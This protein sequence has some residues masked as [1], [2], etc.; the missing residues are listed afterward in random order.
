[1]AILSRGA[2][3]NGL[4][5]I[6]NGFFGVGSNPGASPI[7]YFF[8]RCSNGGRCCAFFKHFSVY[9]G[10]LSIFNGRVRFSI[11]IA[12]ETRAVGS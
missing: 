4:S 11:E 9:K 2:W 8:G 10:I 5:L 7:F 12:S 6:P 3:G 1:M